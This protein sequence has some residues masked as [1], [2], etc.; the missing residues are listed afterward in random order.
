MFYLRFNINELTKIYMRKRLKV[1][2]RL[3]V[4]CKI[5]FMFVYV[6]IKIISLYLRFNTNELT[7]I[8]MRKR[9]NGVSALGSEPKDESSCL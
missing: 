4:N 7:K 2:E 8:N 1:L 3:F 6:L 9:L 5:E